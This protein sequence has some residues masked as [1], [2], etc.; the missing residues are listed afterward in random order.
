MTTDQTWLRVFDPEAEEQSRN[1]KMPSFQLESSLK[2]VAHSNVHFCQPVSCPR[3]DNVDHRICRKGDTLSPFYFFIILSCS[4][5]HAL[6]IL[7]T[8]KAMSFRQTVDSA[9]YRKVF[10]CILFKYTLNNIIK[11]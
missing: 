10:P 4:L 1:W 6:L 2:D 9:Y 11:K 3:Q 8:L 7:F 5:F